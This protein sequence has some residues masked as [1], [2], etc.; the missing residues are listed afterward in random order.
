MEEEEE[1]GGFDEGLH[2]RFAFNQ[3]LLMSLGLLLLLLLTSVSTCM[4]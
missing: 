2:T 3:S 4:A 1:E